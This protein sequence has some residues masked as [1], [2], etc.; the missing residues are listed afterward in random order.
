MKRSSE[1]LACSALRRGRGVGRRGEGEGDSERNWLDW[2]TWVVRS[3]GLP[4]NQ[5]GMRHEIGD[6]F[7]HASWLQNEG[8]KGH[9]GQVHPYSTRNPIVTASGVWEREG[10]GIRLTLVGILG[11]R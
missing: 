2:W 6:A 1:S 8:R 5:I 10:G 3:G 9:P 4:E 7:Q 11:R